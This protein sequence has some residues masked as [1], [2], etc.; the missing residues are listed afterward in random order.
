MNTETQKLDVLAVAELVAFAESALA[1]VEAA[2]QAERERHQKNGASHSQVIA[3]TVAD[4]L[5][6]ALARVG[7][8][9]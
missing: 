7:G 8:A 2:A 1:Y 3:Q 9:A 5:R 4:G 6:E